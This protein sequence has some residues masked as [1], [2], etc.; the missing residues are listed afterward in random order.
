[1]QRVLVTGASGFVGGHVVQALRARGLAVRC[2]VR[3]TSRTEFIRPSPSELAVGDI[4]D[5]QSLT[6]ALDSV[7]AVVHCAGSTRA[8]ARRDYFQINEQGTRNVLTACGRRGGRIAKIVH[9]SSLAAIG[10]S[11]DGLPVTEESSP[12][13]V[14]YYGESKLAAQR[15][16]VS[17]MGKMPIAIVIPPAVYGPGDHGFLP[18]FKL[19]ARGIVLLPGKEVRYLS[20]IYSRDLAEAVVDV[21]CSERTVGRAY[22][23]E[24]GCAHTWAS[25]AEAIG[26][27]LSRQPRSISLPVPVFRGIGWLGD[28]GAAIS[29]KPWL[30]SSQKIR[31]LLQPAWLCSS[32]QLRDELAFRPQFPLECGIR[33]TLAWY[34]EH[35]WL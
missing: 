8:P 33:E 2:L 22:F 9:I 31:E 34:R 28:F 30:I 35:R 26:R 1:M 24:D 15:L 19:V 17:S 6:A 21:L 16:A 29:G 10:P 13:P 3:P 20:L 4:M 18:Y 11:L 12:H 32:Q 27:A 25:V 23:V 7:D 14:N 5:P